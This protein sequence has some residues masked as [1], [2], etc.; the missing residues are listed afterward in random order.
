MFCIVFLYFI[1]CVLLTCSMPRPHCIDLLMLRSLD[2]IDTCRSPI[3]C[4]PGTVTWLA[5]RRMN[6]SIRFGTLGNCCW[7]WLQIHRHDWLK[8]N[9]TSNSASLTT[10]RL[11]FSNA[12]SSIEITTR[13]DKERVFGRGMLRTAALGITSATVRFGLKIMIQ[14]YTWPC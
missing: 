13:Y 12:N 6:V 9:R 14:F 3:R 8:W 1:C 5:G 11:S 7:S 2:Y 4:W 10:S